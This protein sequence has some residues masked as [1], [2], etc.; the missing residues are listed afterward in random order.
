MLVKNY[1][2]TEYKYTLTV[3]LVE[4]KGLKKCC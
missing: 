1:G 4:I 2:K 3:S